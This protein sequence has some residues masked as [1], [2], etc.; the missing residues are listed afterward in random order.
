MHLLLK[1]ALRFP[2]ISLVNILIQPKTNSF[3]KVDL[4]YFWIY[5]SNHQ[6]SENTHWK[7]LFWI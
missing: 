3:E 1:V 5:T 2:Q 4:S 7:V 6:S